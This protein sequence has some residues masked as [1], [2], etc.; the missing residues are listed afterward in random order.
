MLEFPRASGLESAERLLARTTPFSALPTEERRALASSPRV[1]L[2]RDEIVFAAGEPA[3][4]LYVV[5]SGEIVL[6]IDG[7]DGKSICVSSLGAGG[8]FGELAVLD[9]Y[10]RSVAARATA[11]SALLSIKAA[12]FLALVRSQPDFAM[13]IIADLAAKLRR[14]NGQVSGLSFQSLRG[15]V[16][17]LIATLTD[18]Q[19]SSTQALK[20]TQSELAARLGASREKV[21]G[22]LQALQSAGAIRLARGRI[23]ILNRNALGR[24]TGAAVP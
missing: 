19:V 2:D 21:N 15:R 3:Q 12:Q 1:F 6:E 8:V 23:E 11:P 20:I 22:H 14:T 13:A 16:A 7:L 9:G 10:P 24:F 5:I 18:P 17:S 4:A